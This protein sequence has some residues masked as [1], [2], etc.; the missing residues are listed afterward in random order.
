MGQASRLQRVDQDDE[1]DMW[2]I[3]LHQWTGK[4]PTSALSDAEF[5][6]AQFC[7]ALSKRWH[8]LSSG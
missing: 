7:T 8:N 2:K 5:K 4:K 1:R 6:H 3:L